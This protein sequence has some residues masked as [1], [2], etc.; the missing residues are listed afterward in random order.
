MITYFYKYM[1]NKHTLIKIITINKISEQ[2]E[3]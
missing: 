2:S 1:R 3:S